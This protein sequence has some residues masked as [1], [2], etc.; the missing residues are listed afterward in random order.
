MCLLDNLII[1]KSNHEVCAV[2]MEWRGY[3]VYNNNIIEMTN[4]YRLRAKLIT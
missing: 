4:T 2:S 3:L 1:D